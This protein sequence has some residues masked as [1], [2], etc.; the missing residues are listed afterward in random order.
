LIPIGWLGQRLPSVAT[1]AMGASD[2]PADVTGVHFVH[3]VTERGQFIFSVVTVHTV[4]DGDK[5]DA[6]IREIAIRVVAH[7]QI[8]TA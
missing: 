3:D 4:I 6:V 7:L 1:E 8:V 2:F 5:A